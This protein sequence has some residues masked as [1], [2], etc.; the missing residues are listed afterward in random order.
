MWIC[1]F[2]CNKISLKIV[3]FGI[4]M[5]KNY[6]NEMTQ[7]YFS[8]SFR[9][10]LS[11]MESNNL[12]LS[13]VFTKVNVGKKEEIW[14][15]KF[16]LESRNGQ[17]ERHEWIE[18]KCE[19]ALPRHKQVFSFC[20]IFERWD[21]DDDDDER[22]LSRTHW[23]NSKWIDRWHWI[24]IKY[25]ETLDKIVVIE[26]SKSINRIKSYRIIYIYRIVCRM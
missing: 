21:V 22:E 25:I 5:E 11:V 2:V 1:A 10:I 15:E 9:D 26:N 20:Y 3:T 7:N 19:W 13:G 18:L 24:V 14:I 17:R 23:F 6:T 8:R 12:N 16:H 4:F